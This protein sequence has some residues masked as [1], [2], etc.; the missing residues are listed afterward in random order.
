[1]V[2]GA[3][4]FDRLGGAGVFTA[5]ATVLTAVLVAL[6]T[7]AAARRRVRAERYA[8]MVGPLAE[9][10]ELPYRIRRRQSDD[11]HCRTSLAERAHELHQRFVLDGAELAGEC[12]WLGKRYDLAVAQLKHSAAPFIQEAWNLPPCS[13]PGD[14]N[15]NGWGPQGLDLVVGRWRSELRWRFGWRRVVNV[16]RLFVQWLA[17]RSSAGSNSHAVRE[18]LAEA[19]KSGASARPAPLSDPTSAPAH[20]AL[21]GRLSGRMGRTE[22]S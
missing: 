3:E 12:P 17:A 7:T 19:P 20:T 11:Q 4:L 2:L 18:V 13:D 21:P 1:M 6:F 8:A 14:M 5:A 16:G 22:R 10:A 9:W 15:L